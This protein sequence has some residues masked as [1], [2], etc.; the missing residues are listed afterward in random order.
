MSS[1]EL[2][3]E[4]FKAV[5]EAYMDYMD[6]PALYYKA[7]ESISESYRMRKK[8]IPTLPKGWGDATGRKGVI[9]NES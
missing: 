8:M 3:E 7:L 6:D 1:E 4:Y 9:S 5:W 2:D